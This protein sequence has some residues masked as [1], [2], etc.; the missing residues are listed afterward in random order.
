MTL[1]ST[2]RCTHIPNIV[3]L[4]YRIQFQ[5]GGCG[6]AGSLGVGSLGVG[7]LSLGAVAVDGRLEAWLVME[8]SFFSKL[9]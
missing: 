9:L 8:A 7:S 3:R 4:T 5:D 2:T 6:L 1:A